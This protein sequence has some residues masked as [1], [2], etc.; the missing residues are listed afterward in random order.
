MVTQVE[1]QGRGR[2]ASL[3]AP[4]KQFVIAAYMQE[5]Q[6]QA[7]IGANRSEVKQSL[8]HAKMAHDLRQLP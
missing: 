4:Y 1:C 8:P 5:L 7:G 6:S 3:F 2:R